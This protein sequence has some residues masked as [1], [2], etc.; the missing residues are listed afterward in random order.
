MKSKFEYGDIVKITEEAAEAI[1]ARE[2][3]A[4]FDFN[5]HG[6][7]K[8]KYKI[9]KNQMYEVAFEEGRTIALPQ[10]YLEKVEED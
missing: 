7:I 5:Q 9:G 3:D 8:D 10:S 6:K 2:P 1:C 4:D